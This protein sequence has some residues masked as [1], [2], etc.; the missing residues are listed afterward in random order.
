[1][2]TRGFVKCSPDT[3]GGETGGA[4]GTFGRNCHESAES[5]RGRRVRVTR[6]GS[7]YPATRHGQC[8]WP[9]H[10]GA[11]G[12]VTGCYAAGVEWPAH[13]AGRVRDRGVFVF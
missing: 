11:G 2:K 8:E 5:H 6:R 12:S 7:S 9:A 13:T 4:K 1:M 10:T 3:C